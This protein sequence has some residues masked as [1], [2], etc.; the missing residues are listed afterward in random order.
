MI[1]ECKD[2]NLVNK[3]DYLSYKEKVAEIDAM[4]KNGTGAGSDFLGWVD[5]P[6]NYDKEELERIKENAKYV[7]ENY[8][9]LVVAG[10]GGSYLG[11]RAAIEAINGLHGTK[12]P[13]IIFMG[14]TIDPTYISEVLDYLKDK[15]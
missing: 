7:R 12:K 3:V 9:V 5:Y 8:D 2:D 11:A 4:I 10:I 1:I 15:K 13:E 14:Q 6:L